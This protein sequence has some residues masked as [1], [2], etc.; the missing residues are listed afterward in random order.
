MI[1]SEGMN[2]ICRRHK[3]ALTRAQNTKD[4][5][6]VLKAATAALSEFEATGAYPDQWTLWQRAKD[7]AEL[8]IRLGRP[9]P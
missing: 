3:A 4:P 8:Y 7:D 1:D 5:Q 9:M 6:K 2:R